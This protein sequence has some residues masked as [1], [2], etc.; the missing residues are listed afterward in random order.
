M[1]SQSNVVHHTETGI[2]HVADLS[3]KTQLTHVTMSLLLVHSFLIFAEG[4]KYHYLNLKHF[5]IKTQV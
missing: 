3:N 5:L 4:G 1:S 2:D